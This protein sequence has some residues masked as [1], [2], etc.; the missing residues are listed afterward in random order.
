MTTSLIIIAALAIAALMACG[1]ARYILPS[2]AL[3]AA[4]Y[5]AAVLALA[6]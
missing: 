5:L 2:L 6:I 4:L 1:L 3:M